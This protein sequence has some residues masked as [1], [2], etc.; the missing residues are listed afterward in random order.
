MFDWKWSQSI[1]SNPRPHLKCSGLS[2]NEAGNINRRASLPGG[3]LPRRPLLLLLLCFGC[4]GGGEGDAL[5]E[6]HP[7]SCIF[8]RR[9]KIIK[10][11][12]W[13]EALWWV[14][15]VESTPSIDESRSRIPIHIPAAPAL[16]R[17]IKGLVLSTG[18]HFHPEV[19]RQVSFSLEIQSFF[20]TTV[21]YTGHLS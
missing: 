9:W 20:F 13:N 12:V 2:S 15:S 3:P 8:S 4:G 17:L 14:L 16:E 19:G 10:A 7:K 18:F 5:V 11:K 1:G 21:S 6:S